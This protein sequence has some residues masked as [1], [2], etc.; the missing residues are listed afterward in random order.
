MHEVSFIVLTAFSGKLPL[1]EGVVLIVHLA[2]FFAII[3]PLWVMAPIAPA[4]VALFE[5]QNNGGWSSTGLSAMIAMTT[6]L[7]ALL[8]YDCSLHMGKSSISS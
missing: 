3:V 8:G 6:P 2:G 4:R 7:A 1:L 5:F